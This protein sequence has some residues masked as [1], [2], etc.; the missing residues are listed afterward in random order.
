M[1]TVS[2]M[3]KARETQ[4]FC[5]WGMTTLGLISLNSSLPPVWGKCVRN[6]PIRFSRQGF[7]K[8]VD[9]RRCLAWRAIIVRTD[10]Q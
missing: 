7:Y 1:E 9:V 6:L 3:T 8:M 2:P 5:V 10:T 4:D